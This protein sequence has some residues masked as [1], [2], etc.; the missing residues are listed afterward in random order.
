MSGFDLI[1][2]NVGSESW[3]AGA[4][5][6]LTDLAGV[7]GLGCELRRD[8]ELVDQ[9][10]ATAA[11]G[12]QLEALLW[13]VNHVHARGLPLQPGHLLITGTL[14]RLNV[15]ETGRYDVAC[16]AAGFHFTVTSR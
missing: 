2:T 11:M 3:V 12:D 13:L 5:L 6:P 4:A 10:P 8:G 16:G 9:G 14:G 7:N 1:A 15:A